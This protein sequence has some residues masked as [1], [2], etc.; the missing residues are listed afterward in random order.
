LITGVRH[1]EIFYIPLHYYNILKLSNDLK[2][3][4]NSGNQAIYCFL[5]R[6]VVGNLKNNWKNNRQRGWKSGFSLDWTT[7]FEYLNLYL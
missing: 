2:Q 1:F 4:I 5:D 6:N 7:C 3:Q